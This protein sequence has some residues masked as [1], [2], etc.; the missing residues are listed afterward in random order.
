MVRPIVK[1]SSSVWDPHTTTSISQLEAV[2]RRAARFCLNKSG[3]SLAALLVF[4]KHSSVS[5]MLTTLVMPTLQQQRAR[6]KM[7]YKIIY[8]HVDIPK[9]LFMPCDSC[10][11]SDIIN[12]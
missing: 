3:S 12:N 1:Y 10:L 8:D 11:R 6:A 4:V 5:N 7:M 9:D 2:Q